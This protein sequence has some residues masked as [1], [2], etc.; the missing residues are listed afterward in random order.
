MVKAQTILKMVG[1]Q[2]AIMVHH[3]PPVRVAAKTMVAAAVAV[4]T[5]MATAVGIAVTPAGVLLIPT[6]A[7]PST[8]TSTGVSE[9]NVTKRRN[10]NAHQC[11]NTQDPVPGTTQCSKT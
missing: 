8:S 1:N 4:A 2:V 7:R 5:V 9:R 6:A 11:R 10:L 3:K